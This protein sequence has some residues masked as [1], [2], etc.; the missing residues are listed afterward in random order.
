MAK[1][2]KKVANKKK[3]KLVE[4]YAVRRSELKAKI[5]DVSLSEDQR[6]DAAETLNKLPKNS[7]AVRYR[8]RCELTGR[9]RA[10]LRKFRLSRI[11]FREL[12]LRGM[13]PGVRKSSW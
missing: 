9:P 4:K 6:L 1:L 12:A 13:I 2:S 11:A 8:N 5:L 3:K 7:S 10:F